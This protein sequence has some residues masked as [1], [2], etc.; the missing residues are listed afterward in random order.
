MA[1]VARALA[2]IVLV[3]INLRTVLAALGSAGSL[4][5]E[6][7]EGGGAIV[8]AVSSISA[9]LLAMGA[10]L[11][12]W[13]VQR[14]PLGAVVTGALVATGVA[15]GLLSIATPVTIWAA[16]IV[17]GAAAGV[18]GSLLPAIVRAALPN[19][20]ELG[21]GAMVAATAGGLSLGSVVVGVSIQL[22]STWMPATALLAVLAGA[23]LLS[24]R[25]FRRL[26][27][28]TVTEPRTSVWAVLRE[29]WVR[30]LTAFLAVQ[31][32]ILFAQIAWLAPSL[33]SATGVS[34]TG[35]GA[36]LGVLS[37]LQ[38]VTDI[39]APLL[40]RRRHGIGLMV[41]AGSM[42]SIAGTLV[43]L[44]VLTGGI[45]G[46]VLVLGVALL[47]LGHGASFAT[48]NFAIARTSVSTRSAAVVGGVVMLVSQAVGAL[49]PWAFGIVRDAT[50]G[51]AGSW[52]ALLGLG[53]AQM[54]AAFWLAVAVH[55]IDRRT[56]PPSTGMHAAQECRDSVDQPS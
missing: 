25:T 17:G 8:G 10:P 11:S 42:L 54:A 33:I 27:R 15:L 48:A 31:S 13:L 49:G 37:G 32:G 26:D 16:A 24:T 47:A 3:A 12:I 6:E 38:V 56:R 41:V 19:R 39:T 1:P 45:A 36:M 22:W 52:T 44:L 46:A 23:A 18:L 53:A 7:L 55:R 21:I 14:R 4:I 20:L 40:A 29:P 35:A 9:L 5:E 51:H 28:E 50:G 34:P 30:A 43:V 2:A